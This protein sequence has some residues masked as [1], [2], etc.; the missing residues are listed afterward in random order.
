MTRTDFEKLKV[1]LD[2]RAAQLRRSL[3]ERQ[4]LTI[5]RAAD[6]LD[7]R[8]VAA[9]RESAA[10]IRARDYRLL[11]QLEETRNRLSP[12]TF[13]HCLGCDD[14]IA[15]KRLEAIP[16]AAYCVRC[17]EDQEHQGIAMAA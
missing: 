8:V 16:W 4:D 15:P 12:E 9:Q 11:R 10:Q 6:P 14:E 13:G 2:A 1:A 7:S 3:L 17:Q 5:E